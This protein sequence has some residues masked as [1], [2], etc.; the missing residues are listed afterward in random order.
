MKNIYLSM[1]LVVAGAGNAYAQ[2]N[3]PPCSFDLSTE[4]GFSTWTVVDGNPST[5]GSVF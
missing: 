1:I 5:A 4:Q 2:T 3:T